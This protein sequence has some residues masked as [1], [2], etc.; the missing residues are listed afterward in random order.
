MVEGRLVHN[1][2]SHIGI[3]NNRRCSGFSINEGDFSEKVSS[4]KL[5]DELSILLDTGLAFYDKNELPSCFPLLN[6]DPFSLHLHLVCMFS[7]FC[8]MSLAKVS[9]QRYFLEKIDLLGTT[10]E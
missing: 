9:E 8:Q 3:S 1:Q 10:A 5:P 6:Q 2:E 4:G 7:D